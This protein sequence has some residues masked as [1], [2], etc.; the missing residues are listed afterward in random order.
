MDQ[1][2]VLPQDEY[3]FY[4]FLKRLRHA[5]YRLAFSFFL[6]SS[7]PA[8]FSFTRSF[9]A[10]TQKLF[11]SWLSEKFLKAGGTLSRQYNLQGRL[12]K[13]RVWYI[14]GLDLRLSSALF[15]TFKDMLDRYYN[16]PDEEFVFP[17]RNLTNGD[18]LILHCLSRDMS[19]VSRTQFL[20]LFEPL[21]TR[22][23]LNS[24][25]FAPSSLKMSLPGFEELSF[26]EQVFLQASPDL[27]VL[28]YELFC[29]SLRF[30]NL[31]Q[32][33][34]WME[35]LDQ[36]LCSFVKL[37]QENKLYSMV[38]CVCEILDL[39]LQFELLHPRRFQDSRSE[40][41]EV[42]E[43]EDQNNCY[44]VISCFEHVLHAVDSMQLK[45]RSYSFVDEEF[46]EVQPVL[47]VFQSRYEPVKVK[48]KKKIEQFYDALET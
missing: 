35:E 8:Q 17:V 44:Q 32:I 18:R 48:M 28:D 12:F 10:S 45:L 1:N 24:F 2:F 31:E 42:F 4:L 16:P 37:I 43:T 47:A 41:N 46:E 25:G 39:T 14:K 22:I 38:P 15:E 6:P 23:K 21:F 5:D 26:E 19:K 7:F 9:G 29:E 30:Y 3:Y 36:K 34:E 11:S 20:K 27:I 13:E 33:S 40:N